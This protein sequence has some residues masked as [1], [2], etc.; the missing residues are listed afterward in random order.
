MRDQRTNKQN[1]SVV[2]GLN[3]SLILKLYWRN[4]FVHRHIGQVSGQ[5]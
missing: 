3:D 1:L 2:N 5:D 4:P